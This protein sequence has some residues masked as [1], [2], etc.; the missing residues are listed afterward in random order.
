LFLLACLQYFFLQMLY[1]LLCRYCSNSPEPEAEPYYRLS[2]LILL[3]S[4]DALEFSI[5]VTNFLHMLD[6]KINS[7]SGLADCA[8]DRPWYIGLPMVVPARP[9]TEQQFRIELQSWGDSF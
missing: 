7:R 4:A 9:G 2:C 3:I 8:E 5:V 6:L 1:V